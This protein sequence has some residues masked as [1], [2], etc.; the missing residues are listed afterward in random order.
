MDRER[1]EAELIKLLQFEESIL[2]KLATDTE[3]S[4]EQLRFITRKIFELSG[5]IL[6]LERAL[7]EIKRNE[8]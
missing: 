4:D 3:T 1:I 6:R 7:Q 8:T 2:Y 5:L